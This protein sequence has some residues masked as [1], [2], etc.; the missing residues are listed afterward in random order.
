MTAKVI[1]D[2]D[3]LPAL[4]SMA[5]IVLYY[6]QNMRYALLSDIHGNLAAF[7][8]VLADIETK[9][10]A[11]I[12]CLGDIV[13]YGPDPVECISLLRKQ[14]HVCIAGNHDWA[15]AGLVDTSEF[16]DTAAAAVRWTS[17]QLGKAEI[18]YLRSLPL[19]LKLDDFTLVHGSPRNP[20]WEYMVS[21]AS[22]QENLTHFET[23]YCLVGHS[24]IPL[25]FQCD[26]NDCRLARFPE[27][28]PL[29]PSETAEY[30]LI[31]NP[32]GVGQPR[33]GDARASYAIYDS[34]EN[35]IYH[36]RVEYD[37]KATQQ[38]MLQLGL[39]ET[40]ALRLNY[41]W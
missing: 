1:A 41:G 38:K 4:A 32:G 14:P 6:Y 34:Q 17:Q 27:N 40:L 39:P 29:D 12:W 30:R 5:R 25:I 24:H 16:N 2:L 28:M 31:I 35:V 11:E 36:Y 21:V 9:E 20:I 15:A 7:E 3:F 26:Q 37:I 13:G 33:D 10:I 22:A 23:K 18:D 19:R 8:A